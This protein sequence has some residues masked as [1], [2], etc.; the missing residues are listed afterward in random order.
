METKEA[1]PDQRVPVRDTGMT[2]LEKVLAMLTQAMVQKGWRITF[3]VG[4]VTFLAPPVSV[5]EM[6]AAADQVMFSVKNSGKN[7][8]QPEVHCSSGPNAA[9]SIGG[10]RKDRIPHDRDDW[11]C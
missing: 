8:L 7:R 11:A 1:E 10:Y 6:I 5:Q 2:D 4:A 9:P 3:S